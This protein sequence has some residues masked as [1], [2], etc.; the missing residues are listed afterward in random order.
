LINLQTLITRSAVWRFFALTLAKKE[1]IHV[2]CHE[3]AKFDTA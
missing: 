1:R 2:L 3:Q